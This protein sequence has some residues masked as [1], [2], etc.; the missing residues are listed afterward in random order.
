MLYTQNLEEIVFGRHEIHEAD[1]LIVLSGYLGP[2][3]VSRLNELPIR[4]RVIYGMYGS[5][6]ITQGLHNSLV[7]IQGESDSVN[8][9]YS[10]IPVHSKCYIWR[11]KGAVSHALIGS[12]NFSINGLTTPY[13]EVLAE[14]TRDTFLALN[15]YV[16]HVFN[17]SI[18]CL[19]ANRIPRKDKGDRGII[20]ENCLVSLLGR[21]GEVQAAAGLN[22]G[23][24]PNN[25]TQPDDA[26]L[27]IRASHIR[28]F[29]ILF[30]PKQLDPRKEIPIGG[31][32]NRHNDAVELIWDDGLIMSGLLEG[33]QPVDGIKY[34]KQLCSSPRKNELGEYL[35]DRLGVPPGQPVRRHHLESYGRTD[36]LLSRIGEGIYQLDFSV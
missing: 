3:P 20:I 8:I 12:A 7:T 22:W 1:E 31:R 29:P 19:E 27:P 25:H 9:F 17:N 6:G 5:E 16:E 15:E 30:P 23:Q 26:Y 35:R 33:S 34:P 21:D 4:S 32:V 24:N 11:V 18:N 14:T 13:R 36:I 2:R 28:D 10:K